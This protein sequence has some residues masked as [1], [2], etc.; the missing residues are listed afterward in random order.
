MMQHISQVFSGISPLPTPSLSKKDSLGRKKRRWKI[1]A[2]FFINPAVVEGLSK[3]ALK[4]LN[5]FL[6]SKVHH[7]KT[8][9]AQ[10]TLAKRL[11]VGR[12]HIN[13]IIGQL[14]KL[15]LIGKVGRAF[16]SC[17]YTYQFRYISYCF[18]I[19]LCKLFNICRY[20]C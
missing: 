18:V 5:I 15:G 20:F 12:Q 13:K 10:L 19:L 6:W 1:K 9:Y 7:I 14:C 8:Y 2:G 17:I 16:N 3:T 4:V 11:G